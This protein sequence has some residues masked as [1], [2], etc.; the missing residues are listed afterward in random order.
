MS[1]YDTFPRYV[2]MGGVALCH[3]GGLLAPNKYESWSETLHAT[4]FTRG[5]NGHEGINYGANSLPYHTVGYDTNTNAI[6]G[7][8]DDIHEKLLRR[9]A[10]DR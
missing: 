6:N 7:G 4:K 3:S 5:I 1:G 8:F 9:L 2:K 10:A